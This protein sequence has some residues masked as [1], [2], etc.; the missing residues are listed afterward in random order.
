MKH[1]NILQLNKL[2]PTVKE[3][4]Y[5]KLIDGD[6]T[7][8][9]DLYTK[10][11]NITGCDVMFAGDSHHES[12]LCVSH[13]GHNFYFRPDRMI[14]GKRYKTFS[15]AISSLKR[16][17]HNNVNELLLTSDLKIYYRDVNIF[18]IEL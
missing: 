10:T 3:N 2:N 16:V 12:D 13:F 7:A 18:N 17:I 14:E 6:Y 4:I 9:I 5:K 1:V 8:E 15:N 11:K